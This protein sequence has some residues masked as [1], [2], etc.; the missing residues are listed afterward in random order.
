MMNTVNISDLKLGVIAGGQLGKM[1]SLAAANWDI[2]TY[3]L[4][5]D[6]TC[7]AAKSCSCFI[8]EITLVMT[9]YIALANK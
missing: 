1:L 2:E 3:V 6:K 4:D 7:P 9:M 5:T 8:E